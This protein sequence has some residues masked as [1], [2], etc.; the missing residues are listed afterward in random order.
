TQHVAQIAR[1]AGAPK[2]KGAGIKLRVKLGD[3]VKKGDILFEIYAERS[4]KLEA[5]LKLA[6]TI[7]P[8][9]VGM[10]LDEK[11]LIDTVPTEIKHIKAFVIER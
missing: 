10:R 8:I 1:E 11:M 9:G 3:R 2:D 7:K 4:T 5:A 6:E